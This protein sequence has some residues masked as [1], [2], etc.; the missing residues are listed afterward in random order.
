MI[1]FGL[2]CKS[3]SRVATYTLMCVFTY[4]HN[5]ECTITY[6]KIRTYVAD[7]SLVEIN[8][9]MSELGHQL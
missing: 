2:L 6:E 9:R 3:F 7:V 4:V 1:T 8:E 5:S